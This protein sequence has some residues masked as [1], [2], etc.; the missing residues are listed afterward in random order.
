MKAVVFDGCPQLVRDHPNP[1][2]ATGEALVSV[3][4][5]GIC[6][7]D[8]EITRGYANFRGVMGHEFVGIVERSSSGDLVGRR[9]VGEINC[10][11][12]VCTRCHSGLA[13]H[14]QARSV[15][16][17]VGR[18]GVMA[19]LIALPERNLHIV[20][21]SVPDEQAVFTEPLAAA[22]EVLEQT[23]LR[24]TQKV[25]VL[26]D[27]K[28]GLLVAQVVALNGCDVLAIGRH[29]EKLKILSDLGISTRMADDLSY[30]EADVV[31]DCTGRSE[32]I[33]LARQIVRPRGTIVIKST[34]ADQ[35][36][37]PFSPMVVDEVS[38][39]GSRCGPFAPA[40]R[41]LTRGLIDPRPLITGIYS[42]DQA[43]EAFRA[44][45]AKGAMKVLLKPQ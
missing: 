5:A 28:L 45:T 26:G 39:V 6:N 38:I 12:G 2:P 15:L 8:I 41:L 19:E 21:D 42:L 22:L 18:D 36:Q 37:L 10:T 20:P 44:A 33:M 9:V 1:V 4:L 13:S 7:T 24:P 23:H 29:I 31:V 43:E 32:G 27:G 30:G 34:T 3:R 17:I 14:C 25:A 40:L 35:S 16:G 11:C